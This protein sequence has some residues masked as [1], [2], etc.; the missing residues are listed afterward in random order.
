MAFR[1]YTLYESRAFLADPAIRIVYMTEK[2]IDLLAAVPDNA[3]I[4]HAMRYGYSWD[5]IIHNP[6]AFVYARRQHEIRIV[7][8]T[9]AELAS[10]TAMTAAPVLMVPVPDAAPVLMVPV[11]DAAPV[12]MVPVPDAAPDHIAAMVAR[13]DAVPTSEWSKE[14]IADIIADYLFEHAITD[15]DAAD[16]VCEIVGS[17]GVRMNVQHVPTPDV[18]SHAAHAAT[19]THPSS[20]D[21]DEPNHVGSDGSDEFLHACPSRIV[22]ILDRLYASTVQFIARYVPPVLS[23]MDWVPCD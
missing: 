7:K 20:T 17:R 2:G 16:K 13:I 11:P 19:P 15:Y 8:T 3:V 6:P 12:L 23:S 10:H 21:N 4:D 5:N 22:S 1:F 14:G 18:S 9:E